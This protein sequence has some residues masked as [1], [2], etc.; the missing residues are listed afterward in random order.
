MAEKCPECLGVYEFRWVSSTS[1]KPMYKNG[2]GDY[3]MYYSSETW[4]VLSG[5][6][7]ADTGVGCPVD[8]TTWNYVWRYENKYSNPGSDAPMTVTCN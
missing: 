3:L 8:V 2:N 4:E 1:G 7:S 6:K 5:F